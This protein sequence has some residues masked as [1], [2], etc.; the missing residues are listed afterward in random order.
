MAKKLGYFQR[1]LELLKEAVKIRTRSIG[2]LARETA[3]ALEEVAKLLLETQNYHLA[4]EQARMCFE[5][6]HKGGASQE[7]VKRS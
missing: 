5:V 6:R 2:S 4:Y 7:V 3:D 1:S